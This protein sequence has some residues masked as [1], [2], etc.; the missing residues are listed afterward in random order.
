MFDLAQLH[1]DHWVAVFRYILARVPDL[2]LAEIED[3]ASDTF[4]RAIRFAD[5]YQD[6]GN[7]RGWLFRIARNV[8]I[9]RFR[10]TRSRPFLEPLDAPAAQRRAVADAGT[11]QQDWALDVPALL[12]QLSPN[13][14]EAI[15]AYFW[16]DEADDETARRLG[17]TR[18][19]SRKRR[20]WALRDLRAAMAG[21]TGG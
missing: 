15:R 16:Q 4:V 17:M 21:G 10:A 7:P 14:R 6:Q 12:A 18:N 5:R 8:M 20:Y 9:D 2:D 13:K 1:Q 19:A 11:D 3:I